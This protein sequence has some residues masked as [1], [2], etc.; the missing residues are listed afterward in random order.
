MY[1]LKAYCVPSSGKGSGKLFFVHRE[2][3][4]T[5]SKGEK[6]LLEQLRFAEL[7]KNAESHLSMK[8]ISTNCDDSTKRQLAAKL[9][10]Y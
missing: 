3:L 1:N 10:R 2:K 9:N 7:A 8:E 4:A 6:S 5:S